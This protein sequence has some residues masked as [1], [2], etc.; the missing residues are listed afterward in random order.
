M[1][2]L[3]AILIGVVFC[4]IDLIYIKVYQLENYRVKNYLKKICALNYA[5]GNKTKLM[6]T[7]RIKRLIFIDFLIHFLI[8]LIIFLI[9]NKFLP[10]FLTIFSLFILSPF[11]EVLTF[12]VA[13]PIEQTIK[14]RYIKKAK[15]KL[16]NC[17]C[18]KI[19]ITGSFGKTTTKN[20]LYQLLK[21]EFDVCATPKSFNTPMGICKTILEKLKETDE[22]LIVEYGARH[23]GDIDFLAKNF[24]VDFG[25]ITPIGNCHLETF[26]TLTNIENTKF[27]LCENAKVLVLFNGKSESTKKLYD[28]CPKEKFLVCEK[29]S[30]AYAKDIVIKNNF[31]EFKLIIDKREINCKTKLLGES[32]VDNIVI[33]SALAYLLK[34]DLFNIKNAIEKLQPVP[35]RLELIKGGIVNVI[36]DSYNSNYIGFKQALNVLKNFDGRKIVVSPGMIELGERQY[37]ENYDIGVE[38]GKVAD[39]FIIMNRENKEALYHGAKDGGLDDESIFFANNREEQKDILRKIIKKGDTVLFENDFPDNIK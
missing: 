20:I 29:D 28:K 34:E 36:D 39:K 16:K 38:I 21:E 7:K 1:F 3:Y 15:E 18:K 14:Q 33:A 11:F 4:L 5:V 12:A 30:F 13:F 31:T 27:E 19:A 26:K 37:Q 8:I 23:K 10:I 35:H 32:N 9:F 17:D 2:V 24:G 25:I 6:F 22:F